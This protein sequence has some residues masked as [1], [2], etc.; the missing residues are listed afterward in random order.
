MET[1]KKRGCVWRTALFKLVIPLVAG[2]FTIA[3]I[4]H[5]PIFKF[6]LKVTLDKT[7]ARVGD[8]VTA[9]VVYKN[10]NDKGI[11]V[12]LPDWIVAEGGK[13]KEDMLVA[14]FTPEGEFKWSDFIL[15]IHDVEPQKRPKFFLKKDEVVIRKFQHTIAEE[16]NLEVNAGAFF[17]Y[18]VYLENTPGF[19][20]RC[21]DPVKIKIIKEQ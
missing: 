15:A 10:T 2:L 9:T 18:G 12:E 19:K 20:F 11:E 17:Y 3:C 7:E 21:F 13:S 6:D 16:E 4:G 8:T 5:E 1:N 14:I